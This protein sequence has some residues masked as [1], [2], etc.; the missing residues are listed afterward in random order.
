M[1]N[2]NNKNRKTRKDLY[3]ADSDFIVNKRSRKDNNYVNFDKSGQSNDL[4][5]P[6]INR[7]RRSQIASQDSPTP[8]VPTSRQSRKTRKNKKTRASF[9][10]PVENFQPT[11]RRPV[12]K[13]H[14]FRKF[15]LSLLGFVVAAGVLMAGYTYFNIKSAVDNTFTG[16]NVASSRDTS[17]LLKKGEP[18]NILLLGTDTGALGRND[19]GRTDTIMLATVNPK[20]KKTTLVSLPRDSMISVVDYENTFPQKLNDAYAFGSTETTIKT[21]QEWLN[22][23]IDFYALVNMGALEKVV[24]KVGGIE[25][26][27]PLDFEYQPDNDKPDTY[28]FYQGES[29]YDYAAD[30]VNF[31]RYTKMDGKA[32]LAF[33]RMRYDDP[34]GDYG[35]TKRQRLVIES[36]LSESAKIETLVNKSFM[37]SLSDNIKTNL[38]F[39]NMMTLV[40]KYR[41]AAKNIETDSLVGNGYAYPDPEGNQIAYE[42]VEDDEKQ[43]IT[44]KIRKNLGLP[45]KDTGNR[46]G[47]KVTNGVS[48]PNPNPEIG[49]QGGRSGGADSRQ[50]EDVVTNP[51]SP[52]APSQNSP[53]TETETDVSSESETENQEDAEMVEIN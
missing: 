49:D 12:K 48:I 15:V 16:L 50:D 8:K 45:K 36:L 46:F 27:S 42:L 17:A 41:G 20:T 9:N 29:Y 23:P 21:I 26:E 13:T 7:R 22:V 38:S 28:K 24:D 35:R 33:T 18:I 51:N 10:Q 31:Q 11:K 37:K 30:G 5:D 39:N 2:Q 14:R 43:R 25:V 40:S 3:Q 52:A 19:K 47:G 1:N 44:N 4:S 34:D 32:T 6:N 53:D